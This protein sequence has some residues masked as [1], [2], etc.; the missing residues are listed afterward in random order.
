[1]LPLMILDSFLF[2]FGIL[3]RLA[4]LW[5]W[6]HHVI[7]AMVLITLILGSLTE[8][9][10][11][12]SC[13]TSSIQYG[14][15]QRSLWASS[16]LEIYAN[17]CQSCSFGSL[18]CPLLPYSHKSST[19]PIPDVFAIAGALAC[20]S[21]YLKKRFNI[22]VR[23]QHPQLVAKRNRMKFSSVLFYCMFLFNL[24]ENRGLNHHCFHKNCKGSEADPKPNSDPSGV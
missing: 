23:A 16:S 12:I 3:L 14:W 13:T 2:I 4:P 11:Y 15:Y 19:Q 1:M 21:F 20:P 18:S 6:L 17:S 22:K 7:M 9:C 24:F 5:T 10:S 8:I